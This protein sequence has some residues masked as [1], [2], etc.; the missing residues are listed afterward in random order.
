MLLQD[1]VDLLFNPPWHPKWFT[2]NA[3]AVSNVNQAR[4]PCAA[5]DEVIIRDIRIV[6]RY[7]TPELLIASLIPQV[8]SVTASPH[9][10][11]F[12]HDF[13]LR[14]CPPRPLPPHMQLALCN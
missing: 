6:L 4:A 3:N 13:Y 7:D 12:P 11:P 9:I 5:C 14:Q 2:G 8:A 1:H 10:C